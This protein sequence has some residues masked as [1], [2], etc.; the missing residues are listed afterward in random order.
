MKY[1]SIIR[2]LALMLI[3][4]TYFKLIFRM[5]ARFVCAQMLDAQGQLAWHHVYS[6]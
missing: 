3:S 5:Y 4:F 6:S 1:V 2:S